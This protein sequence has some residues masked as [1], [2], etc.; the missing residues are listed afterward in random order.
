VRCAADRA[1]VPDCMICHNLMAIGINA[2]AAWRHFDAPINER[3]HGEETAKRL[4]GKRHRL[5]NLRQARMRR[6]SRERLSAFARLLCAISAR[7]DLAGALV[8]APVCSAR[9]QPSSPVVLQD[10]RGP[11]RDYRLFHADEAVALG[12][13]LV[14]PIWRGVISCDMNPKREGGPFRDPPCDLVRSSVSARKRRRVM[15]RTPHPCATCDR[16][17]NRGPQAR[18]SSWPRSKAPAQQ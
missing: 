18:I 1:R 14:E 2:E 5:C 16:P 9:K 4:P 17:R 8:T 13:A 7:S 6:A 10:T 12:F 3:E 15:L 11:S